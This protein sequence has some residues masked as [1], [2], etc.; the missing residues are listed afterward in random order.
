MC[1]QLLYLPG[2]QRF[3]FLKKYNYEMSFNS[4]LNSECT[5]FCLKVYL[6]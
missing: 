1:M 3:V 6:V 5:A 4:I 2:E